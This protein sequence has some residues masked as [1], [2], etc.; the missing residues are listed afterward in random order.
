MVWAAPLP[1]QQSCARKGTGL[2]A[3]LNYVGV[4][5]PIPAAA[6][7]Y[8]TVLA[9]QDDE[10]IF[11]IGCQSNQRLCRSRV[12]CAYPS[13]AYSVHQNQSLLE[14]REN[15]ILSN[16]EIETLM[17]IA[18][19][20]PAKYGQAVFSARVLIRTQYS[21]EN[22][23]W[24]DQELCSRGVGY[25]RAGLIDTAT[26]SPEKGFII[27]P[28]PASTELNFKANGLNHYTNYS[29]T[30]IEILDVLGN[31]VIKKEYDGLVL[32][33]KINITILANGAYFIKYSCGTNEI[34][35]ESFVVH[36]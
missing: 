25:R 30:K 35:R 29:N 5:L 12:A 19:R 3:V 13:H 20:C 18:A 36:K 21:Y 32:N 33:G 17:E 26:I 10:A 34:Y 27:Y 6:F 22:Y 16:E 23:Y 28:N 9:G 7:F 14:Q 4:L 11:L 2:S 31:I 1:L 8:K 24:D 15:Y